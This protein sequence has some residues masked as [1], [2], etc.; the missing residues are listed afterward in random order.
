MTNGQTRWADITSIS[1]DLYEGAVFTLR[2]EN[3]LARTVTVFGDTSS[4]WDRKNT[5]YSTANPRQVGEG[6]DVTATKFERSLL[7][8]LTPATYADQFFLTDQRIRSDTQG[9]VADAAMEQGAA[10]AQQVDEALAS[11]FNLLTGGTIG[12]AGGTVTWANLIEARAMM[13][14]L[15]IP[16]PYWC[17]LHPYQWMYLV[18]SA[19]TTGTEIANAPAFQDQLVN[20]YFRSSIL[21]NVTFVVTPSIA[22]DG[23]GDAIGA[24][25]NR[26]ALAYDVRQPFRVEP[27]RDASRRGWEWN[28][29]TDYAT[30]AWVPARG[31]QIIGDASTPS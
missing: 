22:V 9:V 23:G 8:T 27:Q 4:M 3:L 28:F 10:F 2:Q 16:G 18:N 31:I 25:Y 26:I 30:G 13:H 1:N 15:K 20:N 5:Q 12:T 7:S 29:N 24:M 6:E 21:G 17:A 11:S 14:A 19:L